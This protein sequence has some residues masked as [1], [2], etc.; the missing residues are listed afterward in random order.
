MTRT[1]SE[2][3]RAARNRLGDLIDRALRGEH[4]VITRN[5]KEVAAVVP[6]SV[7]RRLRLLEDAADRRAVLDA[8]HERTYGLDEV[9]RE[10]LERCR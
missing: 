9:L 3:A 7:L 6:V 2:P 10:T 5:G 4:T 1:T 8:L